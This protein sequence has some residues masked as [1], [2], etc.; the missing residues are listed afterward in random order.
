MTGQWKL[1]AA[2]PFALI[3]ACSS[4]KGYSNDSASSAG[5]VAADTTMCA[6]RTRYRRCSPTSPNP[7]SAMAAMDTSRKD[8]TMADSMNKTATKHHAKKSPHKKHKKRVEREPWRVRA[9]PGP[10]PRSEASASAN[11]EQRRL[12]PVR[13]RAN[14][15]A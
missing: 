10:R 5:V 14:L 2:V 3:A 1:A 12:T 9:Q 11:G 6:T 7:D 15:D 13:R 8:S 4:H